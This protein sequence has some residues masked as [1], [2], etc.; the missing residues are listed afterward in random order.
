MRILNSRLCDGTAC[1]SLPRPARR[2]A[3]HNNAAAHTEKE[4]FHASQFSTGFVV[5]NP[6]LDEEQPQILHFVQDDSGVLQRAEKAW[7]AAVKRL[8]P[9]SFLFPSSLV[10]LFPVLLRL[11][12]MPG[13]SLFPLWHVHL[14][15]SGQRQFLL[16]GF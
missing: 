12:R 10:P 9:A 4:G 16:L 13:R 6:E 3:Q 7:A 14:D 2:N 1:R 8:R 11:G 5:V 15:R